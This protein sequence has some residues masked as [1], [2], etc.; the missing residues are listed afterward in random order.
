VITLVTMGDNGISILTVE[1]K[2][3]TGDVYYFYFAKHQTLLQISGLRLII[4]LHNYNNI[5]M[6]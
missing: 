5:L 6:T 2:K 3:L 4:T 1:I